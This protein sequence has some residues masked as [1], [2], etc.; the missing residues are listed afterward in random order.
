[1]AFGARR[2]LRE[3]GNAV[4][5]SREVSLRSVGDLV[6]STAASQA[7]LR[8]DRSRC[9]HRETSAMRISRASMCSL[10]LSG[11]GVLAAACSSAPPAPPPQRVLQPPVMDLSTLGALGMLEFTSQGE[12]P[13]GSTAREQF[14]A[15]LQSAQPG[16]PVIELGPMREV[17]ADVGGTGLNP[18][19]VK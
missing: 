18:A 1:M 4:R 2:S 11:I 10:L 16:T 19:T 3:L 12:V 6:S 14:M 17:I 5:V 13:L 9:A 7:A 8:A 15:A